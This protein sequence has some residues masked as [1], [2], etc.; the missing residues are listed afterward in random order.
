QRGASWQAGVMGIRHNFRF[1][2]PAQTVL[3]C[4]DKKLLRQ[5]LSNLLA[6]AVKY[7]P[8][9]GTIQFQL[10]CQG[11]K[12]IFQIQDWGIGIPKEDLPRLF[13]FFHRGKNVGAIAGTG[14]GLAIVKKCVDIHEGDITVNSEVEVGTLFTV[15]LPLNNPKAGQNQ[16]TENGG[17][18][19]PS[20]P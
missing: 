2:S 1:V 10:D 12:A 5:L 16:G 9:G 11:D 20:N 14:L 15:I 6:N 17:S 13:E 3:A 8:A 4:M 19:P 18:L 7:S